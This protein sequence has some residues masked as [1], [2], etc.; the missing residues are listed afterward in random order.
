MTVTDI[1]IITN[2]F[3]QISWFSWVLYHDYKT[4]HKGEEDD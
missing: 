4:E 2:T 1:A 3:L